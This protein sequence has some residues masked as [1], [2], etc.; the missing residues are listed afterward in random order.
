MMMKNQKKKYK[1][2]SFIE[3]F[4]PTFL[5][6]SIMF[7]ML[8]LAA[9]NPIKDNALIGVGF[10]G[11]GCVGTLGYEILSEFGVFRD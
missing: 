10:W 11:A 9:F 8:M 2:M 3:L 7:V 4:P 1:D 5:M 6:F